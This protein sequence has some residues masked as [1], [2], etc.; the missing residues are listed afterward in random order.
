MFNAFS[1]NY[2]A[3]CFIILLLYKIALFLQKPNICIKY[4]TL[5]APKM[6]DQGP[7][8]NGDALESMK[9][10][11]PAQHSKQKQSSQV[12]FFIHAKH[13][14]QFL[15]LGSQILCVI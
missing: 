7:W 2:L 3:S 9:P 15:L 10:W 1:L 4:L 11:I 5:K 14:K 6:K 13:I 12:A 8:L